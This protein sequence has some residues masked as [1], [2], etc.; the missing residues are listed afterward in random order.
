MEG[1][2]WRE[3]SRVVRPC[4]FHAKLGMPVQERDDHKCKQITPYISKGK[5]MQLMQAKSAY[6]P[7]Y[8]LIG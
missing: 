4:Y 3:R 6:S 8:W 5:D 7:R 2:V 1:K